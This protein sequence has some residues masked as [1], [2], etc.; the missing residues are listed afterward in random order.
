MGQVVLMVRS[1]VGGQVEGDFFEVC[2][3]LVEVHGIALGNVHHFLDI[4]VR[5]VEVA[6]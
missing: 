1:P 3:G 6:L 4:I 5:Q 2:V